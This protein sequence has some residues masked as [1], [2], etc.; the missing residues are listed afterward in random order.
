LV[1]GIR[2]SA[3]ANTMIVIIKTAVV[4]FVIA[5][6]A[7]MVNPPNWHTFVPNVFSGVMSGAAIVFFAFIGFDA[8]STTAEET[9]NPQR[10]MPIGII[11]SL[12]ICTLL[13][14][15]MSIILTGVK[16]YTVY[17]N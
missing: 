9:R 4:V 13:Y 2:E 14:V 10:D 12:I 7:F 17:L 5:L 6:A 16:K 1:Y 3:G 11:A 8:V 15:L